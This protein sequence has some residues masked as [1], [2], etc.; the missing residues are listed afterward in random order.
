MCVFECGR[1]LIKCQ[2]CVPQFFTFQPLT[3][4]GQQKKS[5]NGIEWWAFLRVLNDAIQLAHKER[6]RLSFSPFFKV[7]NKYVL[8][9]TNKIKTLFNLIYH[10]AKS[11]AFG[12]EEKKVLS[13][14]IQFNGTWSFKGRNMASIKKKF[15]FASKNEK[16]VK[17]TL[18]K[19]DEIGSSAG[20]FIVRVFC[21]YVNVNNP[22][23][24]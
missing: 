7:Q 15:H 12:R 20:I 11:I 17:W 10:W 19:S 5:N 2:A 21:A 6:T 8:H 14:Q 3:K 18:C 9:W 1:K 13:S 24:E 22:I 23:D 16:K 4:G